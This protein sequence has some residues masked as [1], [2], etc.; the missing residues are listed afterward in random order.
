MHIL[1]PQTRHSPL[2]TFF[3]TALFSMFL[4]ACGTT[5]TLKTINDKQTRV[6]QEQVQLTGRISIQYQQRE[7]LETVIAG[8][9]WQQAP[10]DLLITLNSPVGTIAT[11]QQNAQ[12]A[13]LTQAKQEPRSA[14]NIE[15]LLTDSFGWSIPVTGLKGWLQG[16]DIQANGRVIPVP[17]QDYFQLQAQGWELQFVRWQ[18]DAGINHPARIDLQRFTEEFGDVKIRILIDK[19]EQ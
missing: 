19:W 12:G 1:L 18:E 17:A 14:V 16:F 15:Q 7:Q 2:R 11:I 4:T 10:N 5:P 13:V 8:F 9:E 3:L 6:L